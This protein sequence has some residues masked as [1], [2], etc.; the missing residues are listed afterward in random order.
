MRLILDGKSVVVGL[1]AGAALVA[2]LG[3]MQRD[4]PQVGR[5]QIAAGERAY[6]V[7]TAT[8]RVWMEHI[9]PGTRGDFIGTKMNDD[10]K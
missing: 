5:F 9:P 1:F 3:A 2:S 7:D 6:V 10:W 8:G 4:T